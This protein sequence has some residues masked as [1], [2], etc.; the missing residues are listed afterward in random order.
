MQFQ[1]YNSYQDQ[2]QAIL[3][4]VGG[5]YPAFL[6]LVNERVRDASDPFEALAKP[7]DVQVF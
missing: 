1:T 7:P 6:D 2:F 5:N 4:E 3:D